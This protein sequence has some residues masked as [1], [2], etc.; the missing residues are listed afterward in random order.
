MLQ[1]KAAAAREVRLSRIASD[2]SSGSAGGQDATS[3]GGGSGSPLTV[4]AAGGG[5]GGAGSRS[6]LSAEVATMLLPHV[7]LVSRLLGQQVREQH[8]SL[9]VV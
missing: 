3:S 5:N 1:A 9:V 8:N 4:A 7:P 6:G 2:S